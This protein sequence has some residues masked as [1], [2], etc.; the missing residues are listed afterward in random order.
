MKASRLSPPYY[1][2]EERKRNSSANAKSSFG[3]HTREVPFE[4]FEDITLR[5][6]TIIRRIGDSFKAHEE[7]YEKGYS[8]KKRKKEEKN[9]GRFSRNFV[10]DIL[11]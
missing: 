2:Y 8:E 3:S 11:T 10:S 6:V 5:F 9:R 4:V 1:R 7:S